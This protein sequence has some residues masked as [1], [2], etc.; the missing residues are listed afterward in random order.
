[1]WKIHFFANMR[2]RLPCRAFH[3]ASALHGRLVPAFGATVF[4][5]AGF[6]VLD[7]KSQE[8][9]RID[10]IN[11]HIADGGGCDFGKPGTRGPLLV[12]D[13]EGYFYYQSDGNG[14]LL[15]TGLDET[16]NKSV[17]AIHLNGQDLLLAQTKEK[18]LACSGSRKTAADC[19]IQEYSLGHVRVI[20]KQLTIKSTCPKA[21]EAECASSAISGVLTIQSAGSRLSFSVVGAC[22]G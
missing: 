6:I 9:I 11:S 14:P 19:S 18:F 10:R 16:G 4:C 12:R 21:L 13:K 1:M 2:P 17:A 20:F 15:I 3:K 7:A 22:S 8:T 5:F